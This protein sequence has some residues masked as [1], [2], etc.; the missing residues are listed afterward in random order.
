ML[1]YI[2]SADPPSKQASDINS[3]F[4][5]VTVGG[6]ASYTPVAGTVPVRSVETEDF[7]GG[8]IKASPGTD[9]DDCVTKTQL[10]LLE[11]RIA[12]LEAKVP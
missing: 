7:T 11:Q 12:A 5:E 8:R 9:P 2:N 6:E 10:D 4:E 3:N 1:K